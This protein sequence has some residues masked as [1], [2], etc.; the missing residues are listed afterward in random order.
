MS[1]G[2]ER[3]APPAL[4]GFHHV[5]RYWNAPTGHWVAQ[6]L[7]GDLYVSATDEVITTVLGSCV[8]ACMRDP[9]A[10][11]GGMNHFM[12]PEDPARDPTNGSCLRYGMS[13]MERL[14]NHILKFG[15]VKERLEVKIFGGGRIIRCNTD[16]GADNVAFVHSYLASE[17]LSVAAEDVGGTVGRRLRYHPLSGRALVKR[18]SAEQTG[19][20]AG[21]EERHRVLVKQNVQCG[22]SVELF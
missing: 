16:I 7:P 1:G 2:D 12:L 10:G 18:L 3:V 15:G 9:L 20:V 11:V 6:V 19:T 5:N 8:S 13:A 14:I 22:G 21:A 4:R 17:G